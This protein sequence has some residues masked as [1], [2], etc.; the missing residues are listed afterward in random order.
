VS[1]APLRILVCGGTGVLGEYLVPLL[2]RRGHQVAVLAR[3]G[4]KAGRIAA[5]GA[6]SVSGDILE[7][8]GLLR[9]AEGRAVV[10]H[11]AT[12]MPRTFPGRP[13][14]FHENDRIR[15]EGTRNLVEAA[16][17]AGASRLVAQSVI[18]VHGDAGGRW[19]DEDAPLMPSPV[20]ASAVALEAESREGASRFGFA[21]EVL[22][23]GAFYAAEAYHTREIISRLR[24]RMAPIIGRGDSYQCF[25]HVADAALG[26][27][28]AAEASGA[29]GTYFVV[30][31]EPVQL[32]HYLAWL[33][34]AVGAPPPLH[35]PPFL[36]RLALGAEMAAAYTASLR[37]RNERI[38]RALGWKP[39]YRTYRDGFAEVLPKLPTVH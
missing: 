23:C 30:D 25:V 13:A 28:L 2:V 15:A 22:R 34:R 32:S 31:D 29:G 5:W 17:R 19:I 37:C 7:R 35:V 10:I 1:G 6:Q 11:A 27:A 18:W 20:A 33:A 21:L 14:D 12:R 24:R 26:F 9:A 3:S 36:A 8:E 39:T 4:E 16:A 38:K